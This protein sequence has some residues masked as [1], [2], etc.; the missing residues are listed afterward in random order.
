MKNTQIV[1]LYK[2]ENNIPAN[3]PLLTFAEWK[4]KGFVVKKGEKAHIKLNLWKRVVNTKED[5]EKEYSY[6]M[7]TTALFTKEQVKEVK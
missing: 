6:I 3:E 7:K 2:I 4:M 5:D 1:N